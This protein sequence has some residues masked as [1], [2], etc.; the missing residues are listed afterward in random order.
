MGEIYGK[1]EEHKVEDS[2][3]VTNQPPEKKQMPGPDKADQF[4]EGLEGV[5]NTMNKALTQGENENNINTI[6]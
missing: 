4:I 5:L 6:S 3:V 2:K 1:K